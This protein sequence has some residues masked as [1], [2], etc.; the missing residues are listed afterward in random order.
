[1]RQPGRIQ[2]TWQDDQTLKL[3]ADAGTQTRLLSFESSPAPG[4]GWQGISRSSWDSVPGARGAVLTGSLKVV[5]TQLKPG[6]LRSNGVIYSAS[7]VLT[8]IP[9]QHP[10]SLERQRR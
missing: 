4:G 6:F 8:I 9:S 3:A 7:A 10:P 2:H 1:M 5:T